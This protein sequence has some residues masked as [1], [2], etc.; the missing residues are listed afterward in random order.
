M[1]GIHWLDWLQ[2]IYPQPS[3]CASS[4]ALA[5]LAG[6]HG[7]WR[8]AVLGKG[9]E[10]PEV[11]GDVAVY[12]EG[13][14]GIGWLAAGAGARVR[15]ATSHPMVALAEKAMVEYPSILGSKLKRVV[16]EASQAFLQE[17]LARLKR[18]YPGD[19]EGYLWVRVVRC[20]GGSLAPVI[21][22]PVVWAEKGVVVEPGDGGVRISS[23]REGVEGLATV[24]GRV[25][26]CPDGTAMSVE[27]ARRR[28]R[29]VLESWE[30][31]SPGVHPLVLAAVRREG[32]IV[33]PSPR[34]LAAVEGA[35][36][37][38]RGEWHVIAAEGL[39]PVD[40][41]PQSP[42]RS[43]G[44][45]VMY[46]LFTAR[47]L[48]AHVE[49]ARALR[50]A[51]RE[52]EN[53]HGAAAGDAASTYLALAYL[54]ALDYATAF[55]PWDSR[56]GAPGRLTPVGRSFPP[57]PR[58][59]GEAHLPRL[60]ER[61]ATLAVEASSRA[62]RAAAK[63]AVVQG[64][65]L[66]QSGQVLV[67]LGARGPAPAE[68][69]YASWAMRA[70]G[71]GVPPWPEGQGEPRSYAAALAARGPVRL[72][73]VVEAGVRGLMGFLEELLEAGW[74]ARRT[75]FPEGR[76]DVAVVYAERR[77]LRPCMESPQLWSTLRS[78]AEARARSKAASGERPI[79]SALS[80]AL[81]ALGSSGCW[82][83]QSY[84]GPRVT[85]AS[86][87]E[88][89]LRPALSAALSHRLGWN[90][91]GVDGLT[92]LYLA[93]SAEGGVDRPSFDVVSRM[94]GVEPSSALRCCF[95]E[96]GG[97]VKARSLDQAAPPKTSWLRK[98]EPRLAGPPGARFPVAA[99]RGAG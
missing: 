41:L 95:H 55:T 94:L 17:A 12:E 21:S 23:G 58:L 71:L 69:F 13:L 11:E 92:L 3:K 88:R 34:D 52:V 26:R 24:K 80:A 59:H 96:R 25:V 78:E 64:F 43:Y 46:K 97:K 76:L 18:L 36:E 61:A 7:R 14:G 28:Y 73:A 16:E 47:Q 37:R 39:L 77:G 84:S 48:L 1:A 51:R 90:P 6:S 98:L 79:A 19:A 44:V 27:E 32:E 54:S 22:D 63:G 45:T 40:P 42:P 4:A 99:A 20:P 53:A 2:R 66:P 70:L 8:D 49:A 30:R 72:A 56:A 33:E 62:S 68:L 29:S 74:S 67:A 81:E 87:V 5:A 93:V 57:P 91:S 50:K 31:G 60:L 85:L 9:C 75:S 35:V 89:L 15:V 38:L 83:I 65:L 82:P 10:P 86:A